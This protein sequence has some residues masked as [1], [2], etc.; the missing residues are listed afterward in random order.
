MMPINRLSDSDNGATTT[1]DDHAHS[2]LTTHHS[3]L[4]ASHTPGD[5]EL[6]RVLDEYLAEVEAGRPVDAEEWIARHPALADR[7]RACLKGLQLVEEVAAVSR[8]TAAER[9]SCDGGPELGD[10]Q[11]VRTLGHGGMGVVF[12]A[13]QRSLGRHVA[14][15]VLPFGAA[16]DPRQLARFR[17][18]SQAAA[19]LQHNHIVPV[20]SV[21]CEGGVHYYAMQL[22]DGPTLAGVVSSLRKGHGKGESSSFRETTHHS[23]LTTHQLHSAEFFREVARLGHHAA[24]ALEHAH[25]NGVLHRDVKPSNLMIDGKGHLWVTDFGLARLQGEGS[26]TET[27]DFVGTV[28]YMSP[29]QTTAN[30]SIVDERTDVYSLGATLY[31]LLTLEPAFPGPDRQELLRCIAQDEPR[32][33]RALNPAVPPDFETIVQKAMSK[34]AASRYVTAG[35]LADDLRRFLED[36]P[37]LARRPSALERLARLARRR[38]RVV[39][40]V[41]SLLAVTVIG[42]ALGMILVLAKQ[43]EIKRQKAEIERSHAEIRQQR[44]DA[45][46]AVD[47]MYVKVAQNW[48][49]RQT[50]LQPLQR[51]FLVKAL[52]YYERAAREAGAEAAARIRAAVA[53]FRVGEIQRRLG[54][55]DAAEQAY[56]RA[57]AVLEVE[58]NGNGLETDA[59]HALAWS[60]AGL[61]DLLADTGRGDESRKALERSA[62]WTQAIIARTP[63]STASTYLLAHHHGLL[64]RIRCLQGRLKEAEE[65][66]RKAIEL[67]KAIREQNGSVEAESTSDLGVVVEQSGRLGEAA[68]LYRRAV[69]LDERIIK[70]DPR[71]PAYRQDLAATLT[72]LA[73]ALSKSLAK[74]PESEQV[75]RRAIGLYERLA[76][77]APDVQV[78]RRELATT[79]WNLGTVLYNRGR[80]T[81][82]EDVLRRPPAIFEALA[83]ESPNVPRYREDLAASLSELAQVEWAI[84]QTASGLAHARR[85]RNLYDE[86]NPQSRVVQEKMARNLSGLGNFLDAGHQYAEAEQ[87]CRRAVAIIEKLLAQYP[88]D[89]GLRSALATYVQQAGWSARTSRPDESELAFRRSFDLLERVIAEAP[90][91][92][93]DRYTLARVANNLGGIYFQRRRMDDVEKFNRRAF[94]EYDHLI[95]EDFQRVLMLRGAASCLGNLAVVH[96]S[97]KQLGE[98]EASLRQAVALLNSLPAGET[99]KRDAR[100]SRG[101]MLQSLGAVLKDRAKLVEAEA[102]FRQA[103]SIREGLVAEAPQHPAY[104]SELGLSRMHLGSL[105][106]DRSDVAEGRRLLTQAVEIQEAVLRDNPRDPSGRAYLRGERKALAGFLIAQRDH[107]QAAAVAADLL[108]DAAAEAPDVPEAVGGYLTSCA[109]LAWQDGNLPEDRREATARSYARRAREVLGPAAADG[110]AQSAK[111]NLVSLLVNCP[112]EELRDA[113]LAEKLAREMIAQ[114]PGAPR[115]AYFLG[116]ALYR[117]GDYEGA[118][119]QIDKAANLNHG[120]LGAFGFFQAMAHWRLG[121]KDQAL[122]CFKRGDVWLAAMPTDVTSAFTRAEAA[123]LLGLPERGPPAPKDPPEQIEKK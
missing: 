47:D 90:E 78:F 49:I 91:R 61:A 109:I 67:G 89:V 8:S 13:V 118:I 107:T 35:A 22:I 81:E 12:E 103:Q 31:E 92:A 60:Y 75:Y 52:D 117:S 122:D 43:A 70:M 50:A 110:K 96:M 73:G 51:E 84:G 4:I 64:A 48:L 71:T 45:R 72:R 57:L 2:P 113:A 18:E 65:A 100:E 25:Q 86:L 3:P 6:A 106:A 121:R 104:R 29:E 11:I 76:T 119:A 40:T 123:A 74:T 99:T 17:V 58:Q 15:K 93:D 36:Q 28:R 24:L 5:D 69:L 34:D 23:P 39:I 101:N 115:P 21:G 66:S 44:D 108:R 120:E 112:A 19:Q 63:P 80:L 68:Q 20:Y 56:R 88:G 79:L 55:L 54:Q 16:F 98:A 26:L 37:I 102:C 111:I 53:S 85:A 1:P 32:R 77:D 38:V 97:K 30:S 94:Q 59:L 42:L 87:T 7:L 10:F 116:A 114:S 33:L 83:I 14:L 41:V 46:R 95:A 82:A 27:G 9:S 62:E 105:L